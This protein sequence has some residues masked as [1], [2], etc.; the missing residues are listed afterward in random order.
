MLN[1]KVRLKQKWFWI[2]LIPLLF[3]LFDQCVELFQA[4]QAYTI[5]DALSGGVIEVLALKIVGVAFAILAL[6]GFPVDLTTEGYGDSAYS[7]D[8]D[9]PTPNASQEAEIEYKENLAT[10]KVLRAQHAKSYDDDDD[11]GSNIGLTD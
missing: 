7:L 5:M 6:I 8:K 3:L 1:L 10:K 9:A 4:I 2:T 11:I